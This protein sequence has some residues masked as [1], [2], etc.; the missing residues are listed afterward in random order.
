MSSLD[1]SSNA[2]LI[3]RAIAEYKR[4]AWSELP[5]D[6]S[7]VVTLQNRRK[8][9]VLRKEAKVL[10]VFRVDPDGLKR[11]DAGRGSPSEAFF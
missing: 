4:T 10:A 3:K 1:K 7:N 9:V 11:Q 5:P 2:D 8:Y 6:D